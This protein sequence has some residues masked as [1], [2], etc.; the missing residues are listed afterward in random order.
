MYQRDKIKENMPVAF[1]DF[2]AFN[3][4]YWNP[5]GHGRCMGISLYILTNLY[6]CEPILLIPRRAFELSKTYARMLKMARD[7][8]NLAPT[9]MGNFSH[10]EQ[11]ITTLHMRYRKDNKIPA[12]NFIYNFEYSNFA[13]ACVYLYN[14]SDNYQNKNA[15]YKSEEEYKNIKDTDKH[16]SINHVIVIV[17]HGG[18][19]FIFDPNVGGAL[20]N[21]GS[22]KISRSTVQIAANIMYMNLNY[23]ARINVVSI[24]KPKF[25]CQYKNTNKKL[26][27][28]AL[29]D[30]HLYK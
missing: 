11:S 23:D 14:E 6:E 26:I 15:Y 19:L 8:I 5:R 27:N 16:I 7:P 9:V 4:S 20:F 28:N 12:G 3:Q 24:F 13:L 30:I 22:M 1:K 18:E 17:W 2:F 21:Y 10:L 25:N 29:K